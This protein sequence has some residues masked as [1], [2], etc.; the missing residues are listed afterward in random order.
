MTQ[1]PS[2]GSSEKRIP[3][4]SSAALHFEAKVVVQPAPG[5]LLNHEADPAAVRR[6]RFRTEWLG[7]FSPRCVVALS[8]KAFAPLAPAQANMELPN[9]GKKAAGQGVAWAELVLVP[10]LD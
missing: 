9:G 7:G 2:S 3:A 6:I 1:Q 8:S 5:M 4:T 10:R